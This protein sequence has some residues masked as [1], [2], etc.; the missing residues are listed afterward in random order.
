MD[1]EIIYFAP[2]AFILVMGLFNLYRAL[3]KR[4]WP[5]TIGKIQRNE[6]DTVTSS[7][8]SQTRLDPLSNYSAKSNYGTDKE[9]VL[10]LSYVYVV[11]GGKYIGGQLYSAPILKARQQISGLTAGDKVK[12]FYKPSNPH[13]SF[14]AHSFAWPSAIV[15]L[16]GLLLLAGGAYAQF[17][18]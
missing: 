10:G 11:E 18:A 15:V 9:K 12:V 13:N 16:S 4:S 8:F 5:E 2:G 7:E 14:L 1:Y 3:S 6:V 17:N